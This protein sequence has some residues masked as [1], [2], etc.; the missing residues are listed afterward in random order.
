MSLEDQYKLL[1]ESYFGISLMNEYDLK[2]YVLKKIDTLIKNYENEYTISD[3]QII[4]DNV[5]NNINLKTK[6]QSSLIVLNQINESMELILLI[7]NK[8]K[9]WR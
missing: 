1:V 6:L 7:K 8:L 9:N 3:I 5:I 2:E 4:R